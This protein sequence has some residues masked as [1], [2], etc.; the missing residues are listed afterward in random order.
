MDRTFVWEFEHRNRFVRNQILKWW[1][2]D[3]MSASADF[4]YA[5]TIVKCVRLLRNRLSCGP[6]SQ[7]KLWKEKNNFCLFAKSFVGTRAI[8]R[9]SVKS[10][11]ITHKLRTTGEANENSSCKFDSHGWTRCDREFNFGGMRRR[12]AF[13]DSRQCA[14]KNGWQRV[15]VPGVH[16]ENASSFLSK[17]NLVVCIVIARWSVIGKNFNI[18]SL[19]RFSIHTVNGHRRRGQSYSVLLMTSRWPTRLTRAHCLRTWAP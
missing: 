9:I 12:R 19:H 3:L 5:W 17:N 11:K 15:T 4:G 13:I 18:R 7:R 2:F 1:M 8:T 16:I 10:T 6:L 14:T